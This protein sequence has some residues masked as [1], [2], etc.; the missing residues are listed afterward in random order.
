MP[1]IKIKIDKTEKVT[2]SNKFNWI[3]FL[4]IF[5]FIVPKK[6]FLYKR[7][8]YVA[9]K[10]TP[11]DDK[12]ATSVLLLNTDTSVKNSP[13]KPD[14]PGNPIAPREKIKKKTENLGILWPSPPNLLISFDLYLS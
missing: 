14:V 5:E 1:I 13:I 8:M 4:S 6:T 10:I 3:A 2:T 9:A 12:K 7:S 11:K